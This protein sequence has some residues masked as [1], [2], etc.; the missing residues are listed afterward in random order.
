MFQ[1]TSHDYPPGPVGLADLRDQIVHFIDFSKAKWSYYD[2]VQ[3]YDELP[4]S[5]SYTKYDLRS[6]RKH[7]VLYNGAYE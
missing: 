7:A 4:V 2:Y 3:K 6:I 1:I 5:L